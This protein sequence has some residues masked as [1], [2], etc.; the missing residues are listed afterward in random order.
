VDSFC[1]KLGEVHALGVQIEVVVGGGNIFRR[2]RRLAGIMH[3]VNDRYKGH[4]ALSA[5]GSGWRLAKRRPP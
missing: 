1:G 5:D 4:T 2:H 3:A